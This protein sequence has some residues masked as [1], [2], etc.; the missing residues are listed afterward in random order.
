MRSWRGLS[1]DSWVRVRVPIPKPIADSMPQI[2]ATE[3]DIDSP[4]MV[5]N[6]LQSNLGGEKICCQSYMVAGNVSS[7]GNEVDGFSNIQD[8]DSNLNMKLHC[9]VLKWNVSANE[10]SSEQTQVS[11]VINNLPDVESS[12]ALPTLNLQHV[13]QLL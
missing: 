6:F 5:I 11:I 1:L 10:T 3:L 9:K 8:Y 13:A 12:I 2:I 7:G 4:N